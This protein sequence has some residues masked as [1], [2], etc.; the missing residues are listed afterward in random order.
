VAEGKNWHFFKTDPFAE[1]SSVNS[2]HAGFSCALSPNGALF[3]V[4]ARHH[5]GVEVWQTGTGALVKEL[6]ADD[7]HSDTS[8]AVFFS[9][10]GSCLVTS[11]SSECCFWDV[12]SWSV[13]RRILEQPGNDFPAQMAFSRDGRIFAS[14]HSRN[15]IRLCNAANA[16]VLAELEAPNS[17]F[18]SGLAFNNDGTFLAACESRDVLRLWDLRAIRE[19]LTAL[20]LDWEMP[21]YPQKSS[22]VSSH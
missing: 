17:K 12:R 22:R 2:R 11:I 10:D 13:I 7:G 15:V 21:A 8:A 5:A 4:G 19:Q 18:I 20:N 1:L 6:P 16:Q 3:A 14:T 9:P